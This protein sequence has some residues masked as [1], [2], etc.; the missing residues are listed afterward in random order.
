MKVIK[1]EDVDSIK[2]EGEKPIG[3]SIKNEY[4]YLLAEKM[5]RKLLDK[6]LINNNEYTKIMAKNRESFS[7]FLAEIMG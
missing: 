1:V 6:G 4:E 3:V 2:Y 7:P 5:T